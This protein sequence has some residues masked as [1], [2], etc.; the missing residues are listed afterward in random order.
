MFATRP[1]ALLLSLLIAGINV[2]ALPGWCQDPRSTKAAGQTP[3]P[4]AQA[5]RRPKVA[6]A[7]GGGGTRGAAHVGVLKVLKQE[8]IPIDYIVGTSMGSIVGGLYAAGLPISTLEEKFR[9]G[10]LMHAFM[11]VP[12]WVRVVAE[13]VLF[14]PRLVGF[15]PYDGLYWGNKF[16]KYIE[17]SLPAGKQ[18]IDKLDI[19]FSAVVFNIL[20]CQPYRL[21]SGS[22]GYALQASSA[23]PGLRKPVEIGDGLYVDGGVAANVPVLPA[24]ETGADVIIAVDVDERVHRLPKHSFRKAGSVSARMLTYNLAFIDELQLK[25]A[26]ILIHPNVDGINLVS[27]RKSDA[28]RAM[29]AGEKAARE[30]IPEIKTKLSAMGLAELGN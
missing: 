23:V 25:H 10:S 5:M 1:L 21:T 19:P 30:A 12:L 3:L 16:R 15:H 7:L 11:T 4:A 6:L 2:L 24:R 13:P 28:I 17:R 27:T 26:D 22:V 8:G 18:Q 20:D 29:E 14:M 9:D